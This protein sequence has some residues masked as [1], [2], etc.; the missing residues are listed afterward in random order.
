MNAIFRFI[1]IP[2][3]FHG[4]LELYILEYTHS[5]SLSPS[6]ISLLRWYV[7]VC[8]LVYCLCSRV[9]VLLCVVIQVS[10]CRLCLVLYSLVR[11]RLAPLS[12]SPLPFPSPLS[13]FPPLSPSLAS[14]PLYPLSL[15]PVAAHVPIRGAG[16][17]SSPGPR[18][19]RRPPTVTAPPVAAPPVTASTVTA[20]T[21]PAPGAAASGGFLVPSGGGAEGVPLFFQAHV[22]DAET[23]CCTR[24]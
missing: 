17:G 23:L 16:G 3:V 6:A 21:V 20:S 12:P 24:L 2:L 14:P 1:M 9:S 5:L 10:P 7:N 22:L 18:Q 13:P 19:A 15:S 4:M 8:I 11:Q